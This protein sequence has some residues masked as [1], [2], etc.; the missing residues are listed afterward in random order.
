MKQIFEPGSVPYGYHLC[1]NRECPYATTCL[2]QLAEQGMMSDE[3]YWNIISPKYQ[4]ALQGKCPDYRPDKKI[5]YAKGFMN[6][7]GELTLN[8]Y[9]SVVA[10]LIRMFG[11]R[12][13]Y[14]VRKGERLLTPEEQKIVLNVLKRNGVDKPLQFDAYIE[15]YEW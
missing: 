14:R 7:L 11:Q 15:D 5:T 2:R 9:K 10:G 13:Y 12:S 1:L 4:A 6:I 8:Q 3:K